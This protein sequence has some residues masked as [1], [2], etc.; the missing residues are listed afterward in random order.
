MKTLI[1]GGVGA[2]ATTATRLRRNDEDMEIMI[3]E[4]G[5]DVSFS[6][7]SLPYAIGKEVSQESLIMMSAEKFKKQY[8]IDV[9]TNTEVVAVDSKKKTVHLKNGEELAFDNLVLTPGADPIVPNFEGIED[10]KYSTL[11]NVVDV[12]HIISNLE[13]NKIKKVCVIG[14]GFIGLETAENLKKIGLEVVIIDA[15]KHLLR[16]L[17]KEMA[18]LPE[19]ELLENDIELLLNRK[20]KKFEN[21][22]LVLETGEKIEADFFIFSLG[23]RPATNFLK[24]S[25]ISLSEKGY[26]IVDE[27]YATN[28]ENIY[29]AGDSILV[30]SAITKKT[31]PLALAGPANKQGRLIADTIAGK[32]INNKGYIGSNV[33]KV[34]SL[35][36][37]STG[38]TENVAKNEGFDTGY[39]LTIFPDKVG[40]FKESRPIFTKVIYDKKTRKV[41]GAQA[42]SQGASDKR[43]DVIATGIKYGMIIDDIQDLELCYAPTF[44][45]GKDAINKAGYVATNLANNEF[46]QISFKNIYDLLNEKK[47]IIDVRE[48][49]EYNDS[50]IKGVINIPL[51]K[52]RENLD[53]I[54][55]NKMIYVHCKTGHRSYNA[56]RMLIQKGYD[57]INV[58]GGIDF[59]R[60]L[61]NWNKLKDESY[62]SI[63]E[64]KKE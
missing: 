28:L 39:S 6:N 4:R 18:I 63:L 50:R 37:A 44:A 45:T 17:D 64:G 10:I 8:N 51:S 56:T 54:D 46:K 22:A 32:K 61:N 52:I 21:G 60:L 2:G 13:L 38:L 33:V 53:K 15:E 47:Q 14:G 35:H 49:D 29:A 34:F 1:V 43:I 16:T 24:N 59:I 7:C 31:M 19:L 11:K 58:T 41:L 23:I 55:K 20:A 3:L 5:R 25:G 57:A 36:I 12:E 48:E 40:I 27:T 62:V 42:I 9:K 30:K 26:I